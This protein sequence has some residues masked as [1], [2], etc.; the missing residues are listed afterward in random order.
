MKSLKKLFVLFSVNAIICSAIAQQQPLQ[1]HQHYL[2]KLV[3]AKD[4]LY[5]DI[6]A[7]FDRQIL[8]NPEDVKVQLEKC[9]IIEK[10]YYDSYEDY[11]PNY[12]QAETCAKEV[13]RRF[14]NNP[15]ALLYRTEFI[16]GD[17]LITALEHLREI[18]EQNEE[19]WKDY[20]WEVYKQLAEEYQYKEDHEKT[21]KFGELAGQQND[22]L[23]IS[24]LLAR[25]YKN[26]ALTSKAVRVLLNN[27]DS[28]DE[29]YSLNQKGQLLL[30]LGVP[31]KAMEAFRM[32]SKKNS[33]LED[34]GA[35]AQAMIDNGLWTEAR[36][37]LLK[38]VANNYWNHE[39]LQKLM[40]YDL[41]YS[42]PDS[43]Q[44]SYSRY[45]SA[46]FWNDPIGIYR[47]RLLW[48]SPSASWALTDVGRIFLLVAVIVFIFLVPYLWVLPIHY[49]GMWQ[50]RRGKIFP[51]STFK[52]GLRHFWLI[53]SLW[54]LCDTAAVILFDYNGVI[55]LFNS[56][57]HVAEETEAIS[58]H[59]ANFALFFFISSLIFTMAFLKN[60]DIINFVP[61][62]KASL[63]SIGTGIGLAFVLKI[64]LGIFSLILNK[65][66][67]SLTESSSVIASI[68]ESIISINKFY[69]PVLG[70]LFVVVLVPFYEEVLFRGIFLSA[71]ERNMRFVYANILQSIVFALV[72]QSL[73]LF[74]F[75]FAFGM[76]AGHY[77]QKSQGLII[78]TSMHM[79]NNL[80]AF[81]AIT[82]RS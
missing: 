78:S 47:I 57:M 8:L 45:V 72:H 63:Q 4:S 73:N 77:R 43:S 26:L 41:K 7:S 19:I 62:I 61:K 27:L 65:A 21:A 53:C 39:G 10:A 30:D 66:G 52:W 38:A 49:Y 6:L 42:S 3:N 25:A 37:Y 40:I 24:L 71:C 58:K 13:V 48:K 1:D 46:D 60:E 18:A 67:I 15:E 35:L 22:T 2:N 70:F 54:L 28:T 80:L 68:N 17:S 81:V 23:D 33:D 75:Y 59:Q 5:Q 74:V 31:D 50:R 11:N 29:S 56:K 20:S 69:N 55:G 79:M 36:P 14:P 16:Y 9:R 12:D 32:S 64:G 51:E 76:I 34:A 82:L 44:A